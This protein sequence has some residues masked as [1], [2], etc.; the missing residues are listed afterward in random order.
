MDNIKGTPNETKGKYVP[1]IFFGASV[2]SVL[3]L[4]AYVKDWL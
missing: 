4:L 2:G 3:G 1:S